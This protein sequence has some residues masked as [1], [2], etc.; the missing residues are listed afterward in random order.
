MSRRGGPGRQQG[1]TYGTANHESLE[2]VR[3]RRFQRNLAGPGNAGNELFP[4][5]GWKRCHWSAWK[6]S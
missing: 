3:P 5:H 4:N 1:G 2:A 6:C